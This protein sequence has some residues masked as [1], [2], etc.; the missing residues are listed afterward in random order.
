MRTTSVQ[1]MSLHP[2][3]C[4]QSQERV[5]ILFISNLHQDYLEEGL[6]WFCSPQLI[7]V[8]FFSPQGCV[9]ASEL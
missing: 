3:T 8:S 1:R 9:K 5:Y 4:V 6:C 7:F 2:P